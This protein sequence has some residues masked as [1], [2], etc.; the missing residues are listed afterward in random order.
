MFR[1]KV[2]KAIEALKNGASP[3]QPGDLGNPIPT[4][5]GDVVVK[6]PPQEGGDD[7]ELI[8]EVSRKIAA[9]CESGDSLTGVERDTFIQNKLA[10]L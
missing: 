8:L 9:V 3:A 6:A 1:R 5:G 2:G 10:E 4:Y 7:N